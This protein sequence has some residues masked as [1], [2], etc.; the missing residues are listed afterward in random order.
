MAF[1]IVIG[2]GQGAYTFAVAPEFAPQIESI[3]NSKG[4]RIGE[5]QVWPVRGFLVGADAANI[6]SKWNSLK[7]RLQSEKVNC[8]FKKDGVTL[9]SLL[10]TSAERGP[11]FSGPRIIT[12][13]NAAWDTNLQFNFEITAEIYDAQTDVIDNEFRIT[14]RQLE[15]GQFEQSKSGR[16]RTREGTSAHSAAAFQA[17]TAPSNYK[18]ITA[19]ITKNDDDTEADYTYTIRSLFSALP[20]NVLVAERIIDESIEDGVKTTTYRATFVGP[21][22]SHA[23]QNFKPEGS[24][25]RQSKSVSED[26][27]SVSITY[28]VQDSTDGS[29]KLYYTN[30]ISVETGSDTH[31]E[32]PVE[33]QQPIIFKGAQTKTI[34]REVGQ[35]VFK[36]EI[37]PA[38]PPIDDSR[39]TLVSQITTVQPKDRSTESEPLTFVRNWSYTYWS[40]EPITDA[41]IPS[42]ES[43][44]AGTTGR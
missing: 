43:V 25:I 14:Y 35:S 26:N 32:F 18:L 31:T 11:Q 33:G 19:S 41:S 1:T 34:V 42:I 6:N 36:G 37:P 9:Q 21:G 23:A 12:A 40:A 17:L 4:E 5:R 29:Q 39:L 2:D 10:T 44:L 7:A 22:A 15:N 16:V 30:S 27:N 3:R 8:Y 13:D 20:D 24:V 28:T 38:H